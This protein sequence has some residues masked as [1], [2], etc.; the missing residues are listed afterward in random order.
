[1]D[2]LVQQ[3]VNFTRHY[4]HYVCTPSRSSVQSGRLPVHVQT[5]VCLSLVLPRLHLSPPLFWVVTLP[6]PTPLLAQ[7]LNPD[8]PFAG[9][10]RNMTGFAAKMKLAG[11]KTHQVGKWDAG[12]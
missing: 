6:S 11:Y 9:I 2:S 4:V 5:K 8:D 7:L 3:G 10:P 12:T 1:M